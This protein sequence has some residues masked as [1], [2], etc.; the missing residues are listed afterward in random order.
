MRK[1][2]SGLLALAKSDFWGNFVSYAIRPASTANLNALEILT[3]FS[4]IANAA[5]EIVGAFN[6]YGDVMISQHKIHL[7]AGSRFPEGNRVVC[8][9]V[10]GMC[11]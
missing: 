5:D 11:S 8:F 1:E 2:V 9:G 4:E 10:A 3:G 6:F 7:K